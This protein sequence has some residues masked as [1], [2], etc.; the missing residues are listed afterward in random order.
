MTYPSPVE[1]IEEDLFYEE[2]QSPSLDQGIGY[3]YD[4]SI[5]Q[6]VNGYDYAELQTEDTGF[7]ETYTQYEE[8]YD[9][10]QDQYYYEIRLYPFT[11]AP[12]AVLIVSLLLGL[13]SLAII[14]PVA[15]LLIPRNPPEQTND[16]PP[17]EPISQ[18]IPIG[19]GIAPLFTPP[20]QYWAPQI[21]EWAEK[22]NLDPNLIATVMQIESCGD[23][24]AVSVA[25][26]MGLFQVMPFHFEPGED[27]YDPQTNAKRGLG[28]LNQAL[29]ARGGEPRLA[30][31]GYNG[32]IT[33]AKRP[34]DQWPSE[35]KRYVY[36]GTGIY[37]D[38]LAG[39]DQSASLKEWLAKGGSGL[40]ERASAR[41]GISQ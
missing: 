20:I 19:T 16:V 8:R 11:F 37:E 7:L 36:W 28:Y 39:K 6:E 23:P 15:G 5:Y 30:L 27:G 21:Q 18:P 13:V 1:Y 12:I 3:S 38:A 22:W 4:E 40:C 32:G 33:G 35:T 2:Y 41:L 26:A 24:N 17:A 31:A 10:Q 14:K 25:G 34:E 9:P 29:Q